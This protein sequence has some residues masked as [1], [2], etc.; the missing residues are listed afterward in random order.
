MIGLEFWNLKKNSCYF[1]KYLVVA[2]R[3]K[4]IK[5]FFVLHD[6][7]NGMMVYALSSIRNL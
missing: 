6:K 2:V 1:I 4:V 3:I 5:T 7:F